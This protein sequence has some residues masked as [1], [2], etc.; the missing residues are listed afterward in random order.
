MQKT[1]N[2]L[3]YK[4]IG[5]VYYV[6]STRARSL[7]IRINQQGEVRVTIPRHLSQRRAERFFLSKQ[8]WVL[9]RLN[10]LNHKDCR[11][12]VP[13]EGGSI[14]IRGREY[15]VR[16]LQGDDSVEAAIWRALRE[17]ALRYLPGRVAELSEK[18]GF[19][20]TGLKIRKMKTRWG[21]C[22]ARRSINLNSWLMML[23]EQLSDYV[24]LHELMHTRIP[25]HGKRFWEE[26]DGVTGG[27]S[28]N[29]RRELRN[30]QIMCFPER[31]PDQ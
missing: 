16:L 29:F 15:P 19:Q 12:T 27:L 8:Q 4:G 23:P 1:Q 13:P 28:K 26:L 7:A 25:D 2:I 3:H 5:D 18:H 24:I 22:T 9:K 10:G 31:S 6:R 30:H 20:I 17:E 14:Q 21:S 11:K